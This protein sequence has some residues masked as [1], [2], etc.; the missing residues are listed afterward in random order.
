MPLPAQRVW[1]HH[2][3]ADEPD[4]PP[5]VRQVQDFH[6]DI[7]KWDDGGYSFMVDRDGQVFEMRGEGVKGAHTQGDNHQSH[8]ICAFGNYNRDEP[9]EAMLTAI[10]DLLAYGYEQGWWPEPALTGGH[11]DA[12]GADTSCPGPNLY[13]DIP[14]I[15]ET[16]RSK[17]RT[18]KEDDMATGYC[19]HGDEG[20]RV[21]L[22]QRKLQDIDGDALPEYGV[23]EQ[24]GDETASELARILSERAGWG[25]WDGR[26]LTTNAAATLDGVHAVA[27]VDG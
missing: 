17:A 23:D 4:G 26:R 22:L 6:M 16:A 19:E 3:G 7:R 25:E 10:A 13:E 12:A 8:G 15:N 18:P 5:G 2:T 9:T 1:L 11:Q 24:Y 14:A 27:W 20:W 21:G